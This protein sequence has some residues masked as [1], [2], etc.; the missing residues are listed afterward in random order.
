MLDIFPQEKLEA[1]AGNVVLLK[2]IGH[3]MNRVSK[4]RGRLKEKWQQKEHLYLKSE[5]DS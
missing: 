4:Q 3:F 2:G 1:A 5:K